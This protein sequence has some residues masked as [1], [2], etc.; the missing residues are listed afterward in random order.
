[1]KYY[2]DTEFI[3]SFYKPL[4]GK[5]RHF[6]DLISIGI[7][8]E[9][10]RGYHAIS[11]EYNYYD[12]SDWVK[13]NVIDCLYIDTVHGDAR[14]HLKTS[15]FQSRFGKSNKMIANDIWRFCMEG[16]TRQ[17]MGIGN[18]YEPVVEFYGYYADYDWV[19]FCSLFG[20]M[21]DLPKGFPMYCIDLKQTLDELQLN[22]TSDLKQHQR[23]PKQ[24]NEH[25]ALSDAKWNKA[26]HNFLES[27]F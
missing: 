25:N 18:P 4:L 2:I 14:N 8:A 9:D 6:I 19:L 15:N 7:V 21:I 13:E 3:E 10:G 17:P 1:M 24:I 20:T 22:F 12:A 16:E 11:N 5:R 26:L 27:D 23:Y